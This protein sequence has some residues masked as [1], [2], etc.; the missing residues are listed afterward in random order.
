MLEGLM[1]YMAD[2]KDDCSIGN[3]LKYIILDLCF[4]D[5]LGMRRQINPLTLEKRETI[6]RLPYHT[7]PFLPTV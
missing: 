7:I 4:L 1:R 3:S 6:L 5:L 2:I